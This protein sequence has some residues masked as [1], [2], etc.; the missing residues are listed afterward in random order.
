MRAMANRFGVCFVLV[1]ESQRVW[2]EDYTRTIL[3]LYWD[4]TRIILEQ[5]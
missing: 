4:D 1:V 3:G 5:Y 2:W